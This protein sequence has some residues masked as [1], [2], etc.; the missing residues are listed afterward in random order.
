MDPMVQLVLPNIVL[1]IYAILRLDYT[2]REL[3]PNLSLHLLL[4]FPFVPTY[5]SRC[6]QKPQ[7]R[8]GNDLRT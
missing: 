1:R 5:S 7:R 2:P 3:P 6:Y 4:P 8:H